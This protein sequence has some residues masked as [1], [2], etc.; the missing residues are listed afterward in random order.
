MAA[1]KRKKMKRIV[2]D[3]CVVETKSIKDVKFDKF[4]GLLNSLGDRRAIVNVI[5]KNRYVLF[6]KKRFYFYLPD[7]GVSLEEIINNN[8]ESKRT[9]FEFETSE[10]L[11]NWLDGK[12]GE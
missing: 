11:A 4:Y 3:D 10:E 9:V 7:E 8:I 5:G 6:D 12:G 2:Q 1:N